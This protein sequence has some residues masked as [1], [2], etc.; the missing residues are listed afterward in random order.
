M[1]ILVATSYDMEK[2]NTRPPDFGKCKGMG[3]VL[4]FSSWL[5]WQTALSIRG[6]H[7]KEVCARSLCC[8]GHK[9]Y[10]GVDQCHPA[11]YCT[12][13]EY[14]QVDIINVSTYAFKIKVTS[15]LEQQMFKS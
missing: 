8:K 15:T 3:P 9:F 13:G 2:M 1:Q 11:T 14:L 6:K 12:I 10:L 7:L 5:F 4:D